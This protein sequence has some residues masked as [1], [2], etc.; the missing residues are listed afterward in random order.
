MASIKNLRDTRT[1]SS[2]APMSKTITLK[3]LGLIMF[4][5]IS[6]VILYYIDNGVYREK[7]AIC[8]AIISFALLLKFSNKN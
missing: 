1:S 4:G 8:L 2:K 3:M 6:A 7:L 5:L